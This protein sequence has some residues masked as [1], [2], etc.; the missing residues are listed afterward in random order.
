MS[1]KD[2]RK[3]LVEEV[4]NNEKKLAP[5]VANLKNEQNIK[6]ISVEPKNQ[7]Q[8]ALIDA[9]EKCTFIFATGAAGTGKSYVA[10]KMAVKL[11][12]QKK[13]KN[14]I[15][16]RPAISADED[17]GYLPGDLDEKLD[18]YH[19]PLRDIMKKHMS[20]VDIN[21]CYEDGQ[22]ETCAIAFMRGRTFDDAIVIVD[23]AQNITI[24]QCKMILSRVGKNCKII[25]DGDTDQLDIPT[26]KSG[27]LD[28]VPKINALNHPEFAAIELKEIVRNPLINIVLGLYKK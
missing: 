15:L 2:K 1:K 12:L 3:K 22:I 10:L 5:S 19:V 4:H 23:E 8:Q 27:L 21:K 17:L 6:L 16:V 11:L 28:I 9:I 7:E 24:S 25:L 20:S 18:P 26:N 14:I 13:I